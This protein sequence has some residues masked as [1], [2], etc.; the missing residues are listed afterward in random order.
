MISTFMLWS[1]TI[2]VTLICHFLLAKSRDPSFSIL[3]ILFNPDLLLILPVCLAICSLALFLV[4]C[5]M[6]REKM[7]L[8]LVT[9]AGVVTVWFFIK[10]PRFAIDIQPFN[11]RHE[12]LSLLISSLAILIVFGL[13]SYLTFVHRETFFTGILR[14]KMAYFLLLIVIMTIT[15]AIL[16]YLLSIPILPENMKFINNIMVSEN[17]RQIA[18]S[19]GRRASDSQIW[20]INDRGEGLRKIGDR[21]SS[22]ISLTQQVSDYRV[23]CRTHGWLYGPEVWVK[24]PHYIGIRL[25]EKDYRYRAYVGRPYLSPDKDRVAYVKKV[26]D[27]KGSD[28][29]RY[30]TIASLDG[31]EVPYQ[32]LGRGD[33]DIS[34]IGWAPNGNRFYF[35]KMTSDDTEQNSLWA[36]NRN[37]QAVQVIIE[38]FSRYEMDCHDLAE[39]GDWVSLVSKERMEY[40]LWIMNTETKKK[41]KVDSSAINFSVRSWSSDGKHFAY[42]KPL[43][44]D[45]ASCY[46]HILEI[47]DGQRENILTK[48]VPMIFGLS[49]SPDGKRLLFR[50]VGER[51]AE[52]LSLVDIDNNGSL[53][54]IMDRIF[55]PFQYEWL[56]N[57]SIVCAEDAKL[58]AINI[59]Q[60]T[61]VQLFPLVEKGTEKCFALCLPEKCSLQIQ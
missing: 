59:S 23:I 36:I 43:K 41:I 58:I 19:A 5:G 55:H 9:L 25:S 44:G 32:I 47:G 21:F 4:V 50:I 14:G 52:R 56:D 8:G 45:D 40:S 51:D 48:T 49:W 6:F 34:P 33:F 12:T 35:R 1:L 24:A 53:R 29:E 57:E 60:L 22:L 61:E 54:T 28:E 39:D 38:N 11:F 30:L 3:S 13:A 18:F 15:V 16:R 26:S 10:H 42:I 31:F 2:S 17:G 27:W 20:V 37:A 46:L 7:V